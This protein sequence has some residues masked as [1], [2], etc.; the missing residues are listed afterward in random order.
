M[1]PILQLTSS[2]SAWLNGTVNW[3]PPSIFGL[4]TRTLLVGCRSN[5]NETKS[6]S[7]IPNAETDQKDMSNEGMTF[8]QLCSYLGIVLFLHKRGLNSNLSSSLSIWSK[9]CSMMRSLFYCDCIAGIE[10]FDGYGYTSTVATRLCNHF[11]ISINFRQM[12][13]LPHLSAN[14]NVLHVFFASFFNILLTVICHLSPS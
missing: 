1:Y 7:Q 2:D 10:A 13:S 11:H 9:P 4:D 6:W 3:R 8:N 12:S 5:E 14:K